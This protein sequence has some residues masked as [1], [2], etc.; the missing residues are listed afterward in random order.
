M[1]R[2]YLRS[3]SII[4]CKT[5]LPKK[6]FFISTAWKKKPGIKFSSRWRSRKRL[7]TTAD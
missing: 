4:A 6:E 2:R 5:L 7:M 1:M 3:E